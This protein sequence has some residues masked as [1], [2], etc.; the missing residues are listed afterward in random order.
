MGKEGKLYYDGSI[1]RYD[2]RYEGGGE[3]GGFHCGECLNV[4]IDGK[5]KPT[6]FEYARGDGGWYLIGLNVSPAY[7]TLHG[8]PVRND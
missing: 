5:W 1:G 3:Y 2:I 8:L 4:K 6:R 7:I